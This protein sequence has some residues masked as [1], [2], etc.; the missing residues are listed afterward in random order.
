MKH[1]SVRRTLRLAAS[2]RRGAIIVLAAMMLVMIMAF[3]AFTL[4]IGWIALT[5][6]QLQNA[7]D[8]AALSAAT[9]LNPMGNQSAVDAAVRQAAAKVAALHRN[10]DQSGV[11]LDPG[12]DVTLGRRSWDPVAKKYTYV[13]GAGATPYNVVKVNIHRDQ[14]QQTQPDGTTTTNDGR[15][16]LFFAPVIGA[17]KAEL[18]VEA[19]ATYLPRDVMIVLDFSASMDDDTEYGAF[20]RLK[21]QDV[22]ANILQCWQDLGSPTYANLPYT[23]DWATLTGTYGKATYQIDTVALTASG[24]NLR[25]AVLSFSG[26]GSQTFSLS[27]SAATVG[28]TGSNNGRQ[29]TAVTVDYQSKKMT[30]TFTFDSNSLKAALGL[31]SVPYPYPGGS[32]DEFIYYSYAAPDHIAA[33]YKYKFGLE[34]LINYWNAY[35][36]LYSDTPVLWKTH[37]QPVTALKD[38]ADLFMDY[39]VEVQADDQVGLSIFTYPGSAGAILESGLTYDYNTIKTLY[40]QRQ[41]GHYTANTNI[42]AGMQLARQEFEQHAR[43]NAVRMMILMTDGVA[44]QSSTSASPSQY[45]L[46]E[47]NQCKKDGIKIMAIGL[48]TQADTALLQQVADITGGKFFDVPGGKNVSDLQDQL[49][50]VFSEIAADRPMKLIDPASAQ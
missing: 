28:G 47:A 17:Q 30:T 19:V 15:L 10:G 29:I 8:A 42:G 9:E 6:T 43:G 50:A 23:P 4:D 18:K 25:S 22:E 34:S 35:R 12:S 16:P 14:V 2:A 7:A 36:N 48:G 27:G 46:D 24:T 49:N 44:N 3:M 41:A 13:W 32:W 11:K 26:G 5:K 1:P 20:G 40:R 45:V 39:L 21:R 38:A 33:G 31:N 37:Q